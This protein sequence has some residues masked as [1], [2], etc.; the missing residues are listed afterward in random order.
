MSSESLVSREGAIM[1]HTIYRLDVRIWTK[2]Q[3]IS[4]LFLT[5]L[6]RFVT[7]NIVLKAELFNV[8]SY[9]KICLIIQQPNLLYVLILTAVSICHSLHKRANSQTDTWITVIE[10]KQKITI[11]VKLPN[12]L[13]RL[14]HVIN[15]CSFINLTVHAVSYL[16]SRGGNLMNHNFSLDDLTILVSFFAP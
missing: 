13:F 7:I 3:N 5:N 14:N 15:W 10:S 16:L 4:W 1:L 11:I 2:T 12:Q 8:C 9:S 6:I